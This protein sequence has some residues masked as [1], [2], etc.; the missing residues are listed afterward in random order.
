MLVT[1]TIFNQ[2]CWYRACLAHES[3]LLPFS[4]RLERLI[5]HEKKMWVWVTTLKNK[6]KVGSHGFFLSTKMSVFGLK[7]E[8]NI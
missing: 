8:M 6:I 3:E 7:Y 2:P 5:R 4:A 1:V